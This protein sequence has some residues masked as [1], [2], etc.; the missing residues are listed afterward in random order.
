MKSTYKAVFLIPRDSRKTLSEDSWIIES[1]NRISESI[2]KTIC[3][4]LGLN[5][6]ESYENCTAYEGNEIKATVIHDEEGEIEQI[7]LQ[8]FRKSAE[9]LKK[10]LSE[11]TLFNL[12]VFIP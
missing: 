4:S 10:E 5:F 1:Q 3:N 12:E 7:Y 11:T 9:K 2:A 6:K 8:L